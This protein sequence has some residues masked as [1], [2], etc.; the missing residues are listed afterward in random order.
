[1]QD[2]MMFTY[3][4]LAMVVQ[5]GLS[6]QH[7]QQMMKGRKMNLKEM[8]KVISSIVGPSAVLLLMIVELLLRYP[9]NHGGGFWGYSSIITIFIILNII[10]LFISKDARVGLCFSLL[11]LVFLFLSD[12]F[13]LYVS[14]DTW[15]E[16]GMPDWGSF[17]WE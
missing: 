7:V 14:Y 2:L 15:I 5:N 9:C 13:N 6:G 1:M 4:P 11:C 8:Y 16:R 17:N 12:Y 3:G 10:N